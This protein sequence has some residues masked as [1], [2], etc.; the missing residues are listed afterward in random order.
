MNLTEFKIKTGRAFSKFGLKVKKHSPEILIAGGVV[1]VVASTVM[2]CKA[3][4]KLNGILEDCKEDTKRIRKAKEDGYVRVETTDESGALV[5]VKDVEYSEQDGNKDLYITYAQTTM[6]VAKLYAPA[7]IVG[8]LSLTCIITS[9]NILRKRNAALVAAYTTLDKSFKNYRK[10]VAERFG[11]EVENEIRHDIKAREV[12]VTEKDENGEE[13]EITKIV[14][15]M[16]PELNDEYTRFFDCG[17]MGWDK[18][19]QA[20]LCYLL[21]QQAYANDQLKLRGHLTLN[22]VYEMLDIPRIK[23]GYLLGWVYDEENPIGD[24]YVDFGLHN[25]TSFNVNRFVNGDER[26]VK[27]TFNYDG[28]IYD[29][30]K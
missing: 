12:T 21:K 9:N 29:L 13:K 27:L 8:A 26:A 30:I 5:A 20:T 25:G 17:Q 18:D 28:V 19:P 15:S 6:K 7:V 14:E 10:R 11:D 24:N 4:T 22:D 2:A 3:T 1:G 23:E 16:N